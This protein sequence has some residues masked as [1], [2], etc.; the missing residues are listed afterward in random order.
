MDSEEAES[1]CWWASEE[2][3]ARQGLGALVQHGVLEAPSNKVEDVLEEVVLKDFVPSYAPAEARV[4]DGS[5]DLCT[6]FSLWRANQWRQYARKSTALSSKNRSFLNVLTRS[7]TCMCEQVALQLPDHQDQNNESEN[8]SNSS[9]SSNNSNSS[10]SERLL[11]AHLPDILASQ[12]FFGE[13]LRCFCFFPLIIVTIYLL[14]SAHRPAEPVLLVCLL[15]PCP[16]AFR[17]F[18]VVCQRGT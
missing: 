5:G 1:V 9:N 3:V 14:V 13:R 17:A 15:I 8:S 6:S 4:E 2:E 7:C 11:K 12:L 10:N 16:F 18:A